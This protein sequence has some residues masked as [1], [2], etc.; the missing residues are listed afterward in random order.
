[1]KDQFPELESAQGLLFLKKIKIEWFFKKFLFLENVVRIVAR[2]EEL[3]LRT[4]DKG[5]KRLEKVLSR[6][7][8]N[9]KGDLILVNKKKKNCVD[10]GFIFYLWFSSWFNWIDVW[11]TWCQSKAFFFIFRCFLSVLIAN[12]VLKRWIKKVT[13]QQ[14]LH[15]K[16][17]QLVV[18]WKK[19][20]GFNCF[21]C[22]NT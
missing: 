12:F 21:I 15:S 17:V 9:A 18:F 16:Y 22:S 7:K 13:K 3:F 8:P 11:R 6:L 4:L 2:E 19:K 14:L 10:V 20:F 1:M 5:T